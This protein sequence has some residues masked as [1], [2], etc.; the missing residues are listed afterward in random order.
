VLFRYNLVNKIA[1]KF[2][3]GLNFSNKISKSK[4]HFRGF[5]GKK[6]KIII[7]FSFVQKNFPVEQICKHF[8]SAF[9]HFQCIFSLNFE[10]LSPMNVSSLNFYSKWKFRYANSIEEKFRGNLCSVIWGSPL[11][12]RHFKNSFLK[13]FQRLC[14]FC[15]WNCR[16]IV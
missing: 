7:L 6:G 5:Y 4:L 14:R 3:L 12:I 1:I 10:I 11:K 8:S 9:L 2:I 16:Q 13:I 15:L